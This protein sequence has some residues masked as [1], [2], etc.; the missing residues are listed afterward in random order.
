MIRTP[1][2]NI[3]QPV[4]LTIVPVTVI[5]GALSVDSYAILDPG[6]EATFAKKSLVA[7]LRLSGKPIRIKFGNFKSSV[8]MQSEIV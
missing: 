8:E 1:P 5:K 4:L 7:K 6:S 2:K 3:L